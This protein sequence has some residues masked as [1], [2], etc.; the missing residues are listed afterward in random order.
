MNTIEVVRG[1]SELGVLNES[2]MLQT[3]AIAGGETH[4]AIAL[5]SIIGEDGQGNMRAVTTADMGT[6]T[7]DPMLDYLVDGIYLADG[8]TKTTVA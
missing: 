8:K 3:V 6:S 5:G 1:P 2:V 7:T 4:T